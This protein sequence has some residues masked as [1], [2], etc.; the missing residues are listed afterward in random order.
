[1][2][3]AVAFCAGLLIFANYPARAET[4][5]QVQEVARPCVE[6]SQG[7]L[8]ERVLPGVLRMVVVYLKGEAPHAEAAILDRRARVISTCSHAKEL[9]MRRSAEVATV[10]E[11]LLQR[12]RAWTPFMREKIL[13][14]AKVQAKRKTGRPHSDQEALRYVTAHIGQSGHTMGCGLGTALFGNMVAGEAIALAQTEGPVVAADIAALL[15]DGVER[16]DPAAKEAGVALLTIMND[17]QPAHT[18]RR[19]R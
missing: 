11:Y 10:W 6:D 18:G 9:L 17:V 13:G 5:A 1:M 4:L 14:A 2:R 16:E 3:K 7:S 19:R 12:E 15:R 8:C